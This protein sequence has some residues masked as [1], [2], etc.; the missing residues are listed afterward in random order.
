MVNGSLELEWLGLE[1]TLLEGGDLFLGFFEMLFEGLVRRK[2]IEA[3][4]FLA[5]FHLLLLDAIHRNQV[6]QTSDPIH[7]GLIDLIKL[8]F[9]ISL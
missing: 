1:D 8:C 9:D 7:N 3:F 4:P 5:Q 2:K 6:F